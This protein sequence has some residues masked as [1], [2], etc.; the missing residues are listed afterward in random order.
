MKK[1]CK[2]ECK[3]CPF[4]RTNEW[5]NGGVFWKIEAL[6]SIEEAGNIFSCHR[7]HPNDNVFSSR[8][9]TVND[10]AGFKKMLENIECTNKHPQIVNNFLETNP[11][12]YDFVGWAKSEGKEFTLLKNI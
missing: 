6:K 4:L 2:K 3:E 10:C 9:M 8:V 7:T 1:E 5:R 12:S 11:T